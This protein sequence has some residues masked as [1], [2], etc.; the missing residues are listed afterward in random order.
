LPRI[1]V[2]L[3]YDGA[4]FA[5]WQT[6]QAGV[7]SVQQL[8]EGAFSRIADERISLVCAGRTDAG[9]HA[10]GQIAHF[11]TRALRGE[12]SWVLGANANLPDSISV[13]WARKV[14]DHFHA[15]YSAEA[16]TY[17][18]I[19]LN[20]SGRS[21]LAARR[22]A[23]IH[24]PLSVDAMAAAASLLLGEHDFSAFRAADCQSRS[25]IRRLYALNVQRCGDRVIIEA[26][27]NA[28]LHHMVRNLVGLLLD[29]GVG[30][31]AP[32]WAAAV[33]A[34]RDRTR[35]AA[36]APAEG[37]Y[38]WQVRYPPAFGLPEEALAG[39]G[40]DPSLVP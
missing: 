23:L 15:R 4:Q 27:A 30:K 2:A 24:H 5:G 14:P 6:Q 13:R 3:E 17:R 35:G 1:A 11:D 28:F 16:R 38:F 29:I 37:L 12:R 20:R 19:V 25:P 18:Y 26:V 34:S 32:Q 8:A 22:A 36:T 10:L 33:L 7:A 21:A 9:V 39:I 31:A 40:Y